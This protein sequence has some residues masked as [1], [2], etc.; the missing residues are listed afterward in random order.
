MI[1]CWLNIL[2]KSCHKNVWFISWDMRWSAWSVSCCHLF[3]IH[4]PSNKYLRRCRYKVS[5]DNFKKHPF[6]CIFTVNHIFLQFPLFSSIFFLYFPLFIF[7]ICILMIRVS[8]NESRKCKNYKIL[9]MLVVRC[10]FLIAVI[11]WKDFI[12]LILQYGIKPSSE[13]FSINSTGMFSEYKY[14]LYHVPFFELFNF[15][16][17][18]WIILISQLYNGYKPN[19]NL[20]WLSFDRPLF[21][22]LLMEIWSCNLVRSKLPRKYNI[23]TLV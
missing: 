11:I 13:R 8:N 16:I 23:L 10:N 21:F 19:T 9:K 5:H 20:I 17:S 12:D 7:L 1:S 6:L 14:S 18:S 4:K 15:W 22:S 3:L 2:L